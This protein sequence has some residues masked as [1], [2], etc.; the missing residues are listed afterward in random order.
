MAGTDVVGNFDIIR[1][2]SFG[3]S[4]T[5]FWLALWGVVAFF[6]KRQERGNNGAA[7]L[8]LAIW[9]GFFAIAVNTFYWRVFGDLAVYFGWFTIGEVRTFGNGVGDIIW[10]GASLVAVYLHFYARWK[11]IPEDDQKNWYPL[12]MGFYPN[13]QHWMVR[14]LTFWRNGR[15]GNAEDAEQEY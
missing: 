5:L 9:L 1:W 13:L 2:I 11:S 8:I 7:W 10:K 6:P 15:T 4:C 14:T 12:L 3:V